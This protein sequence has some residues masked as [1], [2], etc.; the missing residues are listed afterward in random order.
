MVDFATKL[1]FLRNG[2]VF[3]EAYEKRQIFLLSKL[4]LGML[5]KLSL[6]FGNVLEKNESSRL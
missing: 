4:G 1:P 5:G 3:W 6:Y 2:K